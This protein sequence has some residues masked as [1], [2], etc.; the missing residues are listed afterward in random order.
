MGYRM[1]KE[2][3]CNTEDSVVIHWLYDG[4]INSNRQLLTLTDS[5]RREASPAMEAAWGAI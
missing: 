4:G 2:D 1:I 5:C 3:S